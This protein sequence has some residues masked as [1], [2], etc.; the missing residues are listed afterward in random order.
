MKYTVKKLA[1]LAG[2]SV[3]TLHHYDQ[4]GLLTPSARTEAGYRLYGEQELLRLQQ[5]LLYKEM[6]LP[7]PAIAGILDDPAF[8]LVAALQQHRAMLEERRDRAGLLLETVNKT[9]QK[10][11]GG[12]DM[13][14]N[15][16][17]YA[18]FPKE[19]AE[20][21]RSE[22]MERWG[23]DTVEQSE[24]ALRKMSKED[25]EKLREEGSNIT[26]GL[27]SL[28]QSDVSEPEVQK[29]IHR[30]YLHILQ[31]WGRKTDEDSLDAYRGLS[32]LY[33][34]DERYTCVDG[35]PNLAFTAFITKAMLF[36]VDAL[37]EKR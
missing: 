6:D 21:W 2:V 9:I 15:E 19:T 22:A 28:M 36:Y 10:L 27:L 33:L 18:G 16:E 8:D 12:P 20:A 32:N 24:Q 30:H 25:I 34:M 17:L 3:R 26:A 1:E 4:L 37:S 7:L 14:T 35:K 5:I 23:K 13:I 29:L 31:W 11:T